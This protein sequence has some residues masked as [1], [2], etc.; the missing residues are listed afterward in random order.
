MKLFCF[1]WSFMLHVLEKHRTT[2]EL[3]GKKCSRR[4]EF[5]YSELRSRLY[6]PVL[7]P[8]K[9]GKIQIVFG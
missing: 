2:V 9:P 3:G 4:K 1:I 5:P 7:N 8:C 6:Y